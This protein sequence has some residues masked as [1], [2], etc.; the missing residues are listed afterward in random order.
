[1][2]RDHENMRRPR[3]MTMKNIFLSA[4]ILAALSSSGPSVAHP[5]PLK[6]QPQPRAGVNWR[7]IGFRTSDGETRTADRVNRDYAAWPD[8]LYLVGRDGRIAD[9]GGR[10]P[11]G[12][13][14]ARI[15]QP[16]DGS[17]SLHFSSSHPVDNAIR[18]ETIQRKDRRN[19]QL[20]CFPAIAAIASN[21]I[22][23]GRW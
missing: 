4:A 7:L 14:L 2:I 16:T 12:F 20:S 8:R 10:C 15:S 23:A 5:L 21:A 17:R 1:M 11:G 19:A 22:S 13:K 18:P 6:R 3:N 9:T